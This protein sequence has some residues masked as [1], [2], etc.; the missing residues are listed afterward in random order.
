M[1]RITIDDLATVI[2][3]EVKNK[4]ITDHKGKPVFGKI[5]VLTLNN[6]IVVHGECGQDVELILT[7]TFKI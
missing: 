5:A 3:A 6:G 7:R 4:I 1:E 2:Q